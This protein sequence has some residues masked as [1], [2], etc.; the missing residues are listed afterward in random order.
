MNDG[1][2]MIE[3]VIER[4][5]AKL[6]GAVNAP[7]SVIYRLAREIAEENGLVPAEPLTAVERF[8]RTYDENA[9]RRGQYDDSK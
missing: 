7:E 2:S 4:I 5:A 8:N 9:R 6:L 1:Q 3:P